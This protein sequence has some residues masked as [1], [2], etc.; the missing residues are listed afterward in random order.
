MSL[1]QE[2][3]QK[4]SVT[5]GQAAGMIQSGDRIMTGNRDCRAVLRKVVDREDLENV[6][7]YAPIV[8]FMLDT[9]TVGKGFR[10]S[11]S[12]LNESSRQLF[13]EGRLDYIPGEYWLYHKV[14]SVG[15]KCNVAFLEVSKPDQNGYMSMGTCTD[16]V[17]QAC[18]DADLVIAETNT[19]FPFVYGSNVIHVSEVDY[20]VDEDA[21]NYLLQGA[22][23]DAD[24]ENAATYRAIGGYL[25]ELI[26]DEATIEV[27][28]GR[29]NAA[30]LMYLENKRDLGVHTEVF[31]EILMEL[32]ER[33]IIT[34]RKKSEKRGKA[35]FTQVVGTKKL[36]D[37]LDHNH[38]V[39]MNNCQEVLNPGTIYRQHRMTAINN[40]VEIDLMGQANAEF[41]KGQ[42]YSGMGGICN[43]ASA[44]A[45]QLEGRSIVVLESATKNEKFS[46]IKPCFQPG[47]PV[48]LPRTVI[49]YVVTEQ[50]VA[51]LAGKTP[52]Q[53][54][55][56]LIQVARPKFREE[57]TFQAR[58]MGLL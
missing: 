19:N 9:E 49:E 11:T 8:N 12:F 7:Y 47:T 29:L 15:L 16:F 17:R 23:V 4:K 44:A 56:E 28:L 53:R 38:G 20:I 54:T 25:S 27:G 55:R 52:A 2:E 42:Q 40:A 48:S 26:P 41:L 33:G 18:K 46:K 45:A 3:F 34:N 57:L 10:P 58:E 36:F 30:S 6:Y 39:E 51:H 43:F 35:V 37:W 1:W 21:E 13:Y 5:A 32:T 14:A 50:G 22:G 31:G 24:E